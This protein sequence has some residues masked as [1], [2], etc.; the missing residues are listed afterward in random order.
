MANCQACKNLSLVVENAILIRH[1]SHTPR[2]RA[3]I[4]SMDGPSGRPGDNPPNSDRLGV[5]HPTVSGLMVRVY[6]HP[7]PPIWQW[8]GV[9]PDLS[10][11]WPFKFILNRHLQFGIGEVWNRTQTQSDGPE[12]L[13]TLG[14]GQ[15]QMFQ[16]QYPLGISLRSLNRHLQMLFLL[17]FSTVFGQI[18]CMYIYRVT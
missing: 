4:E 15:N 7:G 6:C 2:A 17:P 10:P 9:D 8:C 14:A 5:D 3:L 13:L 11:S 18:H 1:Y 16:P 12:P